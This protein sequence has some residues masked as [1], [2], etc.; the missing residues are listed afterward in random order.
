VSPSDK[1]LTYKTISQSCD[2]LS[3]AED[4]GQASGLSTIMSYWKNHQPT[5]TPDSGGLR[6]ELSRE[7]DFM[8][9]N[10]TIICLKSNQIA[11]SRQMD[12]Q[13]AGDTR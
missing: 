9:S 12:L 11:T 2:R 5:S 10:R 8:A 4:S 6:T 7:R 13:D 3:V 1:Q